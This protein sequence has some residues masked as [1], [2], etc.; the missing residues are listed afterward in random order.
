MRNGGKVTCELE[1]G[2]DQHGLAAEVCGL[3]SR[4][5]DLH[6]YRQPV[7]PLTVSRLVASAPLDH[8]RVTYE[9]ESGEDQHGLAAEVCGFSSR[10]HDLHNYRQPVCTLTVSRFVASAPLDHRRVTCKLESGEDQH[11]LAAEVC[12]FSSRRHDLHNYRQPVCPL[13][14]SRFVASA[15]LDHRRVSC[16]HRTIVLISPLCMGF[17]EEYKKTDVFHSCS[18]VLD[19][20]DNRTD[21]KSGTSARSTRWCTTT[22]FCV[23]STVVYTK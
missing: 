15:P 21:D 5:H 17:R 8:R 7:C 22:L 12:G 9:L 10:R 1:N 3:S 13:T 23:V 6:I 2:E 19:I 4:R 14:V 16:P 11:G 20:D 18:T